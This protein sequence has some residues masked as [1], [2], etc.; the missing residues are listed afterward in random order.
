MNRAGRIASPSL[1]RGAVGIIA[2]AA[3]WEAFARSGLFST[4]LTPPIATILATLFRMT[5]DGSLMVNAAYTLGRV[6]FGMAV[7]FLIA[8]PLG[9]LMGR[10]R[11]AERFFLPIVSVLMPIPS[12]AWVP[13]FTLWFGIGGTATICVV[14]YA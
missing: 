3:V 13:L 4:S 12:L 9:M 2:C 5:A 8:V 7:A 1:L 11:L 6:A 10:S 14:V